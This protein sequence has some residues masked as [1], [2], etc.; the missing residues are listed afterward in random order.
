MD[1]AEGWPMFSCR[2][3]LSLP[4]W[5]PCRGV[6]HVAEVS[7]PSPS[8]DPSTRAD[9]PK[10]GYGLVPPRFDRRDIQSPPLSEL[11]AIGIRTKICL[12]KLDLLVYCPLEGR[13]PHCKSVLS[14]ANPVSKQKLWYAILWPKTMWQVLMTHN[15]MWTPSLQQNRSS[16]SLSQQ[17][18][19]HGSHISLQQ[20]LQSGLT[21]AQVER[22][23]EDEVWEHYLQMKA[24]YIELWDKVFSKVSFW[25]FIFR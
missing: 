19:C 23:I 24:K 17:G 16:Q 18:V 8:G 2:G 6:A 12:G 1:L 10:V 7:S 25:L 21:V 5:W 4:L 15:T 3:K 14:K 11:R 22:Y 20:L 9:L 13:C